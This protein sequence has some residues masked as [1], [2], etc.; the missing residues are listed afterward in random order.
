MNPVPMIAALSKGQLLFEC[1]MTP[2]PGQHAWTVD[3]VT[4][5][6]ATALV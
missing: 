1:T 6:G 2:G 4:G 3:P 5:W